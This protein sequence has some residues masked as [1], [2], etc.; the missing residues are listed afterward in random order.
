MTFVLA[1]TFILTIFVALI[2]V[3][4]LA[5]PGNFDQLVLIIIS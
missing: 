4:L 3:D 5:A 2:M 1:L